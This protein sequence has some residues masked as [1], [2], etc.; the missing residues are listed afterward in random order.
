MPEI[1]YRNSE[2]TVYELSAVGRGTNL[3]PECDVPK[4]ALPGALLRKDTETIGLP[5]LSELDVVRHFIHLAQRNFSVDGGFYP[6]GSC[7]MK[8]NPKIS[9]ACARSE[10]FAQS[11]PLQ[12]DETVQGNLKLMHDLQEWLKEI[13]GFAAVSLQPTA[14]AQGELTALLMMRAFFRNCG[15]TGRTQI[16]IPDSAHGTNPAST[17]MAGFE[18]LEIPSDEHGNLD[19]AAL[20]AACDDTVAGLMLTNPNTLGLFERDIETIVRCVHDCGGLVYGDGAN[21]NALAGVVRPGD[22]GIDVMHYN[23]HKTFGTPHGGGGPGSGPLGAGE[24]LAAYLPGPLVR[25]I[26][27]VEK[28]DPG[29]MLFIPEKTIGRM[30]SHFGSFGVFVRAYAYI[31]QH[32]AEGLKQNALH[33]VLNANYLREKLRGV[34]PLSHDRTCMH[35]FVLQGKIEGSSVRAVDIS[36]RLLDYGFHPPT[37]YFPLIVPEALMIEPTETES[38]QTLDAFAEAMKAIAQEAVD[39]P[40]T[41]HTAP[42]TTPVGRLDEVR[43]ARQLKLR[44]DDRKVKDNL[45]KA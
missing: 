39:R 30:N 42:H 41:L 45:N 6:L 38:K 12:P 5:G 33:A 4:T 8:Y 1:D 40:E 28:P 21:M 19:L 7:T 32:G 34:Y 15:E 18:T 10:G 27:N 2:K 9:E 36:K 14:G 26:D 3:M 23:L 16:L 29:Y 17:T 31:L 24:K 43:A 37:I 11:H 44:E 35:E 22:L 13:G 20:N 25:R